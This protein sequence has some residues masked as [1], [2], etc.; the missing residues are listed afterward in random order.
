MRSY[1][2]KENL[3]GSVVREILRYKHTHRQTDI[4]LLNYK[5]YRFP[6]KIL[7]ADARHR[8][9]YGFESRPKTKEVVPIAAMS[10]APY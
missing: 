4:I 1:P 3:I 8:G 5:D 10:D 6:L 7:S 2:V 9:C